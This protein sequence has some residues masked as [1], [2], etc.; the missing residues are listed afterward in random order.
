MLSRPLMDRIAFFGISWYAILIVG[1]ILIG[2]F[3]CCNE[4]RRIH[5]PQ[6]TI[7]DF[8]LYAIPLG[9]ICARL[10]YVAFRFNDYSDNL[11]AIFHIREGGL[12]IYGG[13]S[14]GLSPQ[15]WSARNTKSP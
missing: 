6:D 1:A 12:A 8:M 3:L 13:V 2:Y 11:A 14:A 7:L 15:D 5:L 9:I 10:Y 4:A